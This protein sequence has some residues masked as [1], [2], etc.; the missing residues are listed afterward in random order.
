[1]SVTGKTLSAVYTNAAAVRFL[2]FNRQNEFLIVNAGGGTI[3]AVEVYNAANLATY[4]ITST[5]LTGLDLH[6]G[7]IPLVTVKPET[8][9]VIAL[10]DADDSII[11]VGSVIIDID[12]NLVNPYVTKLALENQKVDTYDIVEALEIIA[13]GCA[14]DLTGAGTGEEVFKGLDKSTTRFTSNVDANGN[15]LI[16]YGAAPAM[17]MAEARMA[18]TRNGKKRA[19]IKPKKNNRNSVKPKRIK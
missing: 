19:S 10:D 15:R 7:T 2:M 8:F 5:A 4:K 16:D 13:A 9:S 18:P 12:G 11:S 3:G 14:G 6:Q 1:M 17:M